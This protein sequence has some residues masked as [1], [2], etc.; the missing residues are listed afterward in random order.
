MSTKILSAPL[1]IHWWVTSACNL[2][3]RMCSTS[4]GMPKQGELT[5]DEALAFVDEVA[6]MKVFTLVIGGGEPF[7]RPDMMKILERAHE[8]KLRLHITTNGTLVDDRIA[9]QLADMH[10]SYPVQVSIDGDRSFH[11]TIRGEGMYD[12]ASQGL[13]HLR[14]FGI[15]VKIASLVSKKNIDGVESVIELGRSVEATQVSFHG[16]IPSGR[17][18]ESLV[19][20][21]ELS[22]SQWRFLEGYCLRSSGDMKVICDPYGDE[23]IGRARQHSPESRGGC[24]AGIT[25]LTIDASGH[26]YPCILLS[27]E[28]FLAG[29][30]R[31]EP[32]HAIWSGSAVLQ[33]VREE[34]QAL[35]E[36][37]AV[38]EYDMSCFG[39]CRALGYAASGSLLSKDPRCPIS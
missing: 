1:T 9:R 2:A 17:A 14:H 18:G 32:L 37:C 31:Q 24:S 21:W 29:T 3:C 38:C 8:R 34:V 6:A 39:G 27:G 35:P 28:E 5:T 33:R 20:A 25:E 23:P 11:D 7:C 13:R 12:R 10:F 4:S 19:D 26:V 15:P 22:P 16:I 30:I 36:A